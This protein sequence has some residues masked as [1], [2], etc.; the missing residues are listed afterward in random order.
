MNKWRSFA[1][2]SGKGLAL[3]SPITTDEHGTKEEAEAVAGMLRERGFGGD[4]EVFPNR[5]WVEEITA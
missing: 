2:W 3:E 1:D 5:T 4:Y